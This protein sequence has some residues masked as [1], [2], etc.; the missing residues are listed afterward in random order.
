MAPYKLSDGTGV[1]GKTGSMAQYSGGVF[2]TADGR[3]V[4]TYS[5]LPTRTAT[6]AEAV[7]HVTGVVEAAL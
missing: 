4:V 3:R 7:E 1:W 2:G 6:R 5:F